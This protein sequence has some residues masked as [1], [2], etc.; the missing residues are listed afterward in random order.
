[1]NTPIS[2]SSNYFKERDAVTGKHIRNES[3]IARDAIKKVKS[4]IG[5]SNREVAE[6]AR[7][8]D[9]PGGRAYE[10]FLKRRSTSD[11]YMPKNSLMGSDLGKKG[12]SKERKYN[13]DAY[14]KG[15]K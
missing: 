5:Q 6:R 15:K 1:M 10:N 12:L 2:K 11:G 8:K 4:T 9:T 7:D 3:K 13:V 14:N